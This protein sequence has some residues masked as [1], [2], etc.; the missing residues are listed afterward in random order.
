M[1]KPCREVDRPIVGLLEY[2]KQNGLL[3]TSEK[4]TDIGS[5]ALRKLIT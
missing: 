2:L 4:L 1:I 5:E 3:D